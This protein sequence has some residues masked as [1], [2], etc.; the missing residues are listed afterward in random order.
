MRHFGYPVTILNTIDPLGKFE[1]KADEGILVGYSVTSK[2]FR[3]FNTKTRKVKENLH[4]RFL[5]NKPNVAGTGPNWLFDIDSLTNCTQDNVDVGNEVSDQHHIVLP[6]WSSISS[7]Y[8]SSDD[9]AEDDKPKDDTSSKTVVEPVNKE[10]QTYKDELDRLISQEKEASDATDSLSKEFEQGCMDQRGA[11]KAGNTNSSNTVS[12]PVNAVSTSGTLSAGGPSSPHLDAFIHDDTLLHKVWRLVNLPYRKKAIETKWV[13]KN[14]KDERGIIV[15]N[16]ARLVAQRHKQEERINYDEVFA[17]MARIEAIRIFLAFASFMGFIVYWMDVKSAFLYA[18]IEYEVYVSQP[19]G[20]I[21]PHFLNK[22]YKVE[23]ALYGLHQAPRAWGAY[24]LLRTAAS[25]PI[26]TQ[27]PLVKD[28]EDAD[29]DVHLYRSM[30]GSLMYLIASR[31]DIMFAVC[32]SS[33]FQVTPKLSHLHA[34]KRIFRRPNFLDPSVDIEAVLKEE[35]N[36]LVRAA[37][38]ASLD[39]QQDSSNTVGS[40]EDKMEHE[41]ELT[42]PVPQTPH[43]LPLS[44]GHTPGSDEGSMTLKELTNL[45]ITLSLR[46]LDLEKV[47]TAQA[48]EIASLKKRVTKLEQRQSSR[49]LGFHPFRAST[50]R[51]HSLGTINVSKQGRKNLKL[52]QKVQDIDDLV[53]E[54]VIKDNDSG[55]KGGSTTE[56][57]STARPYISAT[58]PEVSTAKQKT[59]PPTTTLFDDEDVTITDTLV[60]IKSQK[61]KEKGVAFKDVYDSARPIRSI[62]ALQPLPTIDSKDNVTPSKSNFAA[63]W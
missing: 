12:T 38:T 18:K 54:E 37:T 15:R 58:R 28:E 27:K 23:K 42:N 17:P 49:I 35:G 33:R 24:F 52:Q 43:D 57:V 14:K 40:G 29:V 9:K 63:E 7:T 26:E 56:S 2:A 59:P 60:K 30:I 11:A 39:A 46:V 55:E 16:K 47:K 45:C 36:N 34:V 50:S 13:Y 53:D 44:G 20:F 1:G 3:V 31:P 51:R 62:T 19:P 61:A 22:V 8:K 4:V 25:T 10:D 41:I 32:A 5:K 48:K 6:L 21:D